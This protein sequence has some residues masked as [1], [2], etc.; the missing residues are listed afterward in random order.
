M[1]A[2][3]ITRPNEIKMQEVSDPKP[4]KDEV[5]IE[6]VASGIC[7]TDQHIFQGDYLGTYPIIPGHEFSGVIK[8]LGP[9]VQN[10]KVGDRVAVE[11]N[12]SCGIC[13]NCL[14]NKQHFC[15]HVEAVGVTLPGGFAQLVTAPES[16]VFPIGDLSFEEAAF[17]EPLSCVLHG[18]ERARPQ[19]GDRLLLLGAGPIGLLLMQTFIINGCSDIT[20][21]DL[22]ESRLELATKLGASRVTNDLDS[23]E[24]GSF[25]VVCDATGVA[26]L[27]EKTIELVMPS[28]KVLWFAVPRKESEVRLRPFRLLEKEIALFT[29]YT[30]LR[31]SWQA[32]QLLQSGRLNVR[33]LISH[34]LT[35]DDFGKGL[36]ILISHSEPAMKILIMPQD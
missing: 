24:Q 36:D 17:M 3:V 31:N 9:D 33:D 28:G 12:I 30:S 1:K 35:L 26:S 10:L 20:V 16:A 18:V 2:A 22:D 5:L 15:Q 11:P 34:K 23:L 29:S 7:G 4:V 13:Y 8:A 19:M 6:V 27:L 32:I 25:H 21:V 14:N